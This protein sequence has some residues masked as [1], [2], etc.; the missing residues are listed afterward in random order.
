MTRSFSGK[1]SAGLTVV[2][3]AVV[4]TAVCGPAHAAEPAPTRASVTVPAGV[5]AGIAVFDRQTAAFTERQNVDLQFRS[6]S[7]V[8]L[9]IALD[10]LWLRGPDYAVPAADRTRLD[11]MLRSSDDDAAS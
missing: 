11:A 9:L 5:T 10:F 8:K 7:V 3:C 4:A 2:A 1:L 6:A